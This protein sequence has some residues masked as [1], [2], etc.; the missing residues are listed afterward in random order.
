MVYVTLRS[1]EDMDSVIR[2]LV[3]N[4]ISF[5]EVHPE[6]TIEDIFVELMEKKKREEVRG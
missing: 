4:D 2:A 5:Y 3:E 1:R 6:G